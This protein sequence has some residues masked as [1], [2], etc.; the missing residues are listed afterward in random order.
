[1]RIFKDIMGPLTICLLTC[2][3]LFFSME[4]YTQ[5]KI[6]EKSGKKPDW[7]NSTQKDYIIESGKG[8]SI[9]E[10]KELAMLNVK[11][12][13]VKSI[14]EKITSTSEIKM[15]EER[16]GNSYQVSGNYQSVIQSKTDDLPFIKGISLNRVSDFYWEKIK[17]KKSGYIVYIYH[18]KYP[19]SELELRNI[20]LDYELGQ[21]KISDEFYET[22]EDIEEIGTIEGLLEKIQT[23]RRLVPHL[24]EKDKAIASMNIVKLESVLKSIGIDEVT[25]QKGIIKYFL[26]YDDR[27]FN[28]S[29]KP[30]VT[31][32]CAT[33]FRTTR[34]ADTMLLYYDATDCFEVVSNLISI[35]YRSGNYTI[36]NSF[37]LILAQNKV[38]FLISGT[39][40]LSSLEKNSSGVNSYQLFLPILSKFQ[41]EILIKNVNINF[42]GHPAV[43][44]NGLSNVTL[45]KGFNEIILTGQIPLK[46]NAYNFEEGSTIL[47]SGSITYFVPTTGETGVN[48]FFNEHISIRL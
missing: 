30:K 7:I 18:L 21:R 20:I 45:N 35:E 17:N 3:T 33:N 42:T 41:D 29:L 10:A 6:L 14:A 32:T 31:S 16:Q 25:N 43:L 36:K 34:A 23:I 26:T 46:Q 19:F 22:L 38:E 28:T 40:Q 9:D 47:V 27:H 44:F 5:E 39:I 8:V 11:E 4:A 37:P 12:N 48:K 15:R 13:I 24:D 2:L 1:M